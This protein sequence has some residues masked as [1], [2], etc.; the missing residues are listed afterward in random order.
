MPVNHSVFA[1]AHL[2]KTLDSKGRRVAVIVLSGLLLAASGLPAQAEPPGS[3]ETPDSISTAMN[4]AVSGN[5]F[6]GNPDYQHTVVGHNQPSHGRLAIAP[7]G[8]YR[9]T[10]EPGYLGPDS[11]R[12][13]SSDAVQL[14]QTDLP[15]LGSFSSVPIT[16]G[17]FGS[18]VAPVPG[19]PGRVYGLTDRGPNVDGPAK[20]LKIEAIPD[21]TP[22]IGEFQLDQG[23]AVLLRSIPLKAADGTPMNGQVNSSASTGETIQDLDGRVLPASP[24]GLDSEGL[25]AMPD[26]SFYVSDEYGPFIV[27]FDAAGREID[28]MSPFG[29][30]LPAELANRTPNQ[31]ME[32]LTVTPDGKT[33]VGIMQSALNQPDLAKGVSAKKIAATRIVT[34]GLEDRA[35]HEYLV[36]LEDPATTKDAVSEISALSATEFLIDE[37]DGNL[38]PGGR[39]LFYRVDISDATDVGPAAQLPGAGYDGGKGGLLLAGK[40]IEAT[41]GE[42]PT[43]AAGA[44]LADLGIK[45]AAKK[46]SLDLG[47]LVSTLNPGGAFFGHD[48]IEGVFPFD[49]GNK[50]LISNDNDFGIDAVQPGSQNP[51]VLHPKLLPDGKQDDGEYLVVDLRKLPA[52]PV[53]TTIDIS[54]TAPATEAPAPPPASGTAAATVP[55]ADGEPLAAT[56][57]DL[58]ALAAAALLIAA[59]LA[60]SGFS[61]R[62]KR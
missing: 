28:R 53:S 59:G 26:G 40:T 49:G 29:G 55:V 25:V 37:R 14:F 35:V 36:L 18:S 6:A 20:N 60:G 56:G 43:A 12:V 16:A 44:A 9:Y 50:L 8:D 13:D 27:H 7:N 31:G 58:W 33:L 2:R 23:K 38:Q 32:G 34:I 52:R 1:A 30:G 45:P 51:Y 57:V 24:Y 11:F 3:A 48:K 19:K 41:L 17:G 5:A 46:L 47:A 39:K 54:V 4:T 61:R 62:R 15:A 22:S 10:P 42:R 21:F